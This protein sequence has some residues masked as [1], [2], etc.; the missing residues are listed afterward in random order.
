L[1]EVNMVRQF[2]LAVALSI[3][4]LTASAQ[5]EQISGNLVPLPGHSTANGLT[6]N[7]AYAVNQALSAAG[8]GVMIN[9][10]NYGY[11][12]NLG[13]SWSQCTATNQDGS[14]SW[15]MTFNPRVDVNV[16]IRSNTN[17]QI[18]GTTH[19]ETGTNTG[20]RSR[21]FEYRFSDPRDILTLGNFNYSASTSNNSRIWGMYS[22]AVYTVDPCVTNP[23]S[24][25]QCPGYKTYYNIGDDGH[26]IVPIPFG[27]PFY[28]KLFTHSIFFDN[29]AVSFYTPNQEP[30]RWGASWP[31]G[32]INGN[33]GSQFYY[34]IMPLWTDLINYNGAH[35]TQQSNQHLKYTWENVSQFGNPSSSNTF[36]LEIRPTGFI[37]I[38]YDQ[39][40]VSWATTGMIGN[41]ALGEFA[42]YNSQTSWSV[43]ETV[44]TD[45]SDPLV[46]VNCPGY[47]QAYFDQ[48]CSANALYSPSCP[49]YAAAY[50]TQQC[51]IN[52]LYD[53]ACPG[54][55]TAYY[56][57]QCSVSALYHTGC[58]GYS[59]AYFDQQCSLDPL[60]NEACPGYA[61]A[62]FDQQCSLDSLYNE[63]CSGYDDAYYVQQCTA[64]PLYDSG[65]TGYEVA[66]FDQQCTLNALYNNQCPGYE[67]AYFDQQCSLSPLYNSQCPGFELAYFDQQCS[68]NS[69][70]DSQCPGYTVAYF[71]Q[72]CSNNALYNNQC[73]GYGEA[74]AKKY[75]LSAEPVVVAVA[76]TTEP[77]AASVAE[78]VKETTT[79]AATE[80]PAAS[81]GPADKTSPVQ[82]TAAPASAPAE[83]KK[84][85]ASA[86]TEARP[87]AS[88]TRQAL[89][90]RR[91]AA[92][93]A[94]TAAAA[95][96]KANSGEMSSEMDSAAS[97]EQQVEL[98]NVVMGAMGFVA[99]FD[100]YGRATIPDAAGYKPFV[101]YPGQRNIDS[102]AGRRLL[103]G[104]D[105]LHQDMVDSQYN[106]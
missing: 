90:E 100:A 36:S 22:Q 50:F 89:A 58:P 20:N 6:V 2:F 13:N 41:A 101:I 78:P 77:V 73:P 81:A 44:A 7:Q 43:N 87:A 34:S 63:L 24:S 32:G 8:A 75:I 103:T 70:Y 99:G 33:M 91:M 11:Q 54:Y 27:F 71:N 84:E 19:I 14:C 1:W 29:G 15:T 23:Q 69:L 106:K 39:I 5:T 12:Y 16:S 104:S 72:Q 85:A 10:F 42:T 88:A 93:A 65:C 17:V 59:N 62:Y 92:R 61:T 80:T 76:D 56:D 4:G 51:S 55:A 82:L 21:D 74:Y 83:T 37:G 30:Q 97:M 18:Y 9:G 96:E 102:P 64:D 3:V 46:N 94:S 66:Y 31:S 28:G 52:T 60:Y 105:R 38:Q 47:A 57:Y 67:V 35:Y 79:V 45:C 68:L 95:A 25:P 40:D 53:P 49:G 26:A 86:R 98:Q 48:Q